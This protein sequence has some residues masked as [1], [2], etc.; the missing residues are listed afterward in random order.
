MDKGGGG[1]GRLRKT[2]EEP[3][4]E[5]E[6]GPSAGGKARQGT[7]NTPF[8]TYIAT[9]GDSFIM[10]LPPKSDATFGTRMRVVVAVTRI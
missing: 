1:G 2:Q 9:R 6:R 5:R 8:H 3:E 4:L 7:R 10:P